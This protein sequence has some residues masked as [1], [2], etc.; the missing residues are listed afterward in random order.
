MY[1]QSISAATVSLVFAATLTAS[2]AES[3]SARAGNASEAVEVPVIDGKIEEEIWKEAEVFTDFIQTE[4][5]EG[6]PATE[7]TEVRVLYD[8]NAIYIGV[9]CFDRDPDGIII[10]DTRRDSDLKNMDAFKI[11][12]DTYHDKQNGFVFGTNPAGLE[13]DGQVTNDG[14]S[15]R[16]TTSRQA[17][18]SGAGF[19]LN[20]DASWEVEAQINDQGWSAEFA[21]PLRS[22]RYHSEKP[23]TWGINFYRNI[24]RK[25]EE[26]YWA[27]ISRIYN[28]NRV[29]SAGELHNLNLDTPRNFKVTPYVRGDNSRDYEIQDES[30]LDGTW[31][32]DAK[33]G[34]TPSLNLDLTYNTDFA[35]V[36]VDEQ[37]VNLTRFNLF[38]PEKRTFFLENAG[39]FSVGK[40]SGRDQ[41]VE[42]FFSRK[43]GIDDD[44]GLVPILAGAR[45]SGK[46]GP[47]AVGFLNMQ[48]EQVLGVT[49]ADNFTVA[50]VSREFPNRSN[51]GG[52]FINRIATGSHSGPNNWNRT[53]GVDGK[54]GIGEEWTFNGFASRTETPGL[55]GR[56]YAWSAKAEYEDRDFTFNA[57]YTEVGEDFNP[58]VGFL[59]RAGY[60][61]IQGGP[62]WHVRTPSISWLRELRPHVTYRSFWD[63][64]GYQETEYLHL[65][66]HV[67]WEN[68]AHFSPATN[69]TLEGLKEPF[70]IS[71]GIVIPPGKY[72]NTILGWRWNTNLSTPIAYSGTFDYGGFFSGTQ[73]SIGTE[74]YFRK[75]SKLNVAAKWTYNDIDLREGRF[76][77]NL[78]QLRFNYSFTP[79]VYFQSLVQY[80]DDADIWS[81]NLRFTWLTTAS[82]GLYVVYN[83]TEGLGNLL[84]GP[85]Q[86]SFIVKY[87]HQFDLLK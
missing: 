29:S 33:F 16:M 10:A 15:G 54:L 1:K 79:S 22:L 55:E 47:F 5:R 51:V 14:Q 30:E 73:R 25:N 39:F 46:A 61:S 48:T 66:V 85:Q 68:G 20:W 81:A 69:I 12:L 18:G 86:R 78:G 6:E 75:G 24:R 50:R 21:I 52:I 84:I 9:I 56:E 35:Q 53:W 58:E 41:S 38:F 76:I 2:P 7:K 40:L 26:D 27:P 64:E 42:L 49:P 44:G 31:G 72:R 70:E 57:D 17:S 45:L 77:V 37:Q 63:F 80:N 28:I 36:E 19:N 8:D 43:I 3:T 11:I 71:D 4:P 83:T 67:D 23:Q 74:L 82:T 60:R 65:D 13:Y 59:R 34:V 62:L 32:A 87:T